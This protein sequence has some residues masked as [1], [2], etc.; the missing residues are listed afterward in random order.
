MGHNGFAAFQNYISE[1]E[2]STYNDL[3]ML[4]QIMDGVARLTNQCVYLVDFYKGEVPYLSY[5]PIF[6]CNL[7]PEDVKRMG[8][9]FNRKYLR[10]EDNAMIVEITRAWFRFIEQ[11]PLNMRKHYSIQYDYFL[12]DKLVCVSMTPAFLSSD[13]KPWLLIC[14]SKISTHS[15]PGNVVIFE[16]NSPYYWKYC[17]ETKRWNEAKIVLLKEIEQQVIRLSIQGKKENEICR[18][19]FRSK[20]GL[21]SIKRKMFQKMEVNNITEAVSFAISHGLI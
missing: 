4:I 19:I 10:P 18:Q 15:T 11:Q 21:K 14:N 17:F 6:L 2:E 16:K 1:V 13:G 9:D 5:N 12:N 3:Y 20:D 8:S 7:D